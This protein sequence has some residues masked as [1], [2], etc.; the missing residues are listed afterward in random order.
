MR[1]RF[2]HKVVGIFAISDCLGGAGC[3]YKVCHLLSPIE[4]QLR[5]PIRP[6]PSARQI[7]WLGGKINAKVFIFIKMRWEKRQK[8]APDYEEIKV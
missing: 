3:E 4:I 7:K 1:S 6:D 5:N 2:G 8:N